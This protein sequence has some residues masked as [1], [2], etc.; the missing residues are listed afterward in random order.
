MQ[1][2]AADTRSCLDCA[3]LQLTISMQS[4][5]QVNPAL[6][7]EPTGLLA[8]CFESRHSI[9]KAPLCTT[10]SQLRYRHL[11]QNPTAISRSHQL[12]AAAA[13][14]E[15]TAAATADTS[16][17][18]GRSSLARRGSHFEST[19]L[20]LCQG[21]RSQPDAANDA[22]I[23]AGGTKQEVEYHVTVYRQL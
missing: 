17:S 15:A 5:A 14:S 2:V 1:Q 20:A 10:T 9:R 18:L 23:S 3:A 16:P 22:R 11:L 8:A 7:P 13:V 12:R 4:A 19:E 6:W 21:G